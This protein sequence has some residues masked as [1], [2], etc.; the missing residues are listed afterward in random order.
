[1]RER[2]SDSRLVG[3]T[4]EL[5]RIREL[6]E[7]PATGAVLLT[8]PTGVGKSR[9]AE[10]AL[11]DL[12]TRGWR[13]L[14]LSATD[15][16]S[17]IPYGSLSELIPETLDRL[18][19]LTTESAELTVLRSVESALD[20]AGPSPVAVVLDEV[21]A[22]DPQAC[23]LLVHLAT[24]R[25]LFIV[26]NQGPDQDLDEALRRLT[27]AGVKE[28]AVDPLPV[29][30]TAELAAEVLGGAVGPG[31]VRNLYE[32]TQG[33]PLFVCE[34]LAAARAD[35]RVRDVDGVF[36]LSGDLD[37]GP[38]LGRQILFRLGL[39][40][41]AEQDVLELLALAGELGIEDLATRAEPEVLETMERRGL[42]VTRASG[43]RLRAS[44]GHPLHGEAV[45]ANMTPLV[46]RRR[47]RELADLI[48]A[49]G[50]RR[51]E[52]RV[53]GTLARMTAGREVTVDEQLEAV[54]LA[55]RI[56]RVRE[57]AELARAAHAEES[58]ERSRIALAEIL[59]RLGRFVEADRFLAE[60]SPPEADEWQRLRRA[61]RRSSNRL[62]GFRDSAGALQ[63]DDACLP[64][65][66]D[67]D[68]IDRVV[69]HQAWVD[70]CDGRPIDA[71]ERVAHLDHEDRIPD[72]RF[73]L[74]AV[75]APAQILVGDVDDAAELSQQAWDEGWGGDTEYGSRGQHLIALGFAK[76]YQGDVEAAR[77]VAEM[78]IAH[79]RTTS[80]NTGLLFFLDQ[81]ANI[82]LLAGDLP[83]TV[84]YLEEAL[85]LGRDLAIATSVRSSLATLAAAEAQLGRPERAQAIWERFGRVPAAPS[86]R[87]SME[88]R[89][90]EAWVLASRGDGAA[91]AERL[92]LA[93]ADAERRGLRLHHLM[94]LLDLGRL[95]YGTADDGQVASSLAERCQGQLAPAL[96]RAV[97]ACAA[98]EGAGLDR[99]ADELG[100]LGFRL[101][102]AEL[103][104]RAADSWAAAGEP[105]AAAS[106][107]RSSDHQ[108]AQLP[109][110]MT[111]ALARGRSVEPLTRREREIAAVAAAGV[112]NSQIAERLHVSVRT[113]ETHLHNI[114]RKLGIGGRGELAGAIGPDRGAGPEA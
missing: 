104:A 61:I 114:Y 74:I 26:A 9:L 82:E 49:T 12:T 95:G 63:I 110:A 99:A 32:R 1:M 86:P 80:E 85:A 57:G 81:A 71:L 97:T 29:A 22:I 3:R 102:S 16:G 11:V 48:A 96:A 55:L 21:A 30:A 28:L 44:H 75:R 8:G 56:D 88:E 4:Q 13:G 7:D 50:E 62:W 18:D 106:S 108:R 90:G 113:V 65:L 79:C 2:R 91:A 94:A 14:G 103:S 67:P 52:D 42:L 51:A 98:D 47:H 27:P 66:T 58:S 43:R 41:P 24:N 36:Q 23:D 53:I 39:L 93:A 5:S 111:P 20:L 34:L 101:W 76:L 6:A 45:R 35:D 84:A 87:G 46:R 17:R 68:A 60:P 59:V 40:T 19:D 10:G 73:A 69:A 83:A 100:S 109:A 64:T 72:V 33:S 92:R 78:A 107:Q 77:F 54:N 37:V 25:R 70:Y 105:R 38:S 89:T 112:A 15:P 31:L